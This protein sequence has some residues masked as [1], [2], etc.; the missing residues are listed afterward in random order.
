MLILIQEIKKITFLFQ[1]F[2]SLFYYYYYHYFF[3][4]YFFNKNGISCGT[5][6]RN[7]F[8]YS[9][10]IFSGEDDQV[11]SDIGGLIEGRVD[12]LCFVRLRWP[13]FDD[14]SGYGFPRKML[15]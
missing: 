9:F 8:V 1:F 6:N 7:L 2:L 4:V 15:V 10:E 3:N 5:I 11:Q 12:A 13:R 14:S